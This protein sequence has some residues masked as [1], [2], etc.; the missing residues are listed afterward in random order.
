MLLPNK[1]VILL[2][3]RVAYAAH[4]TDVF[5][6][7]GCITREHV[8]ELAHELNDIAEAARCELTMASER[9]CKLMRDIEELS[10]AFTTQ[11]LC[12]EVTSDILKLVCKALKNIEPRLEALQRLQEPR[13][14]FAHNPNSNV[15]DLIGAQH[16]QI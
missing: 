16:G 1:P 5:N 8:A 11:I 6:S 10:V 13:P 3:N 15:I 2:K 14:R 12:G 7:A 4:R 9:S